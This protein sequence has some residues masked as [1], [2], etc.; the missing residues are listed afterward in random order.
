MA[1][2]PENSDGTDYGTSELYSGE[3]MKA[4]VALIMKEFDTWEGCELHSIRYAGDECCTKENI[5][6]MNSLKEGSK[7]SQCAEFLSDFHSPK[8]GG[9]AWNP[10][11]EYTDWQW[12]LARTEGG[13][14]ELLTWGNG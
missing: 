5:E 1:A 13:D 7:F 10:D 12:W 4:A 6:W 11:E 14:W 9:G 8:E 3:D 2:E